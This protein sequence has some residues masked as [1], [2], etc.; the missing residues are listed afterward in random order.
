MCYIYKSKTLA[1][2]SSK[3][4]NLSR[5]LLPSRIDLSH[6]IQ[7]SQSKSIIDF[8]LFL[9]RIPSLNDLSAELLLGFGRTTPTLPCSPFV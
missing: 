3:T 8:E 5:I 1:N 2:L 4:W 9:L 7:S 6:K